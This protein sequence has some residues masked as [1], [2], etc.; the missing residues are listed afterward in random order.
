MRHIT[1]GKWRRPKC[2]DKRIL[3]LST[4]LPWCSN[5]ENSRENSAKSS[6][7][8][9]A[10]LADHNIFDEPQSGHLIKTHP[11][12]ESRYMI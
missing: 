9:K 4:Y 7:Q 6:D 3:N 12:L 8:E 1:E 11:S 10:P 2:S 5:K